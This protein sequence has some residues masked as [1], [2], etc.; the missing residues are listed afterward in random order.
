MEI[1]QD[2]I[3][4]AFEENPIAFM[5]GAGAMLMG[6]S[7]VIEATGNY[8]GSSAYARDVNRRVRMAKKVSKV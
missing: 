2:K 1:N 5:A 3:I 7:K 4:R 6:V 8:R